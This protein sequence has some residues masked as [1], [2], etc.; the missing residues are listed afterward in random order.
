MLLMIYD[1]HTAFAD[2]FS[3]SISRHEHEVLYRDV[4][5]RFRTDL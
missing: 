2:Q 5:A 4:T 1:A 3:I